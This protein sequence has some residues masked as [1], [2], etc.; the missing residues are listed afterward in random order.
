[1]KNRL[2]KVRRIQELRRSNSSGYVPSKKAY[3]RKGKNSKRVAV[4]LS[5]SKWQAYH[6]KIIILSLALVVSLCPTATAKN[7]PYST[8][9]KP[10]KWQGYKVVHPKKYS[11]SI[12][13]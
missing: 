4:D 10:S 11:T 1:M 13:K 2:D 7:K 3:S 8:Y 6:M 9:H 12:S 5:M